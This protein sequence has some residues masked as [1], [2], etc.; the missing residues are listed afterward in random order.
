[1]FDVR[2]REYTCVDVMTVKDTIAPIFSRY[3]KDTLLTCKDTI[4]D[5][6]TVFAIDNCEG[7]VKVTFTETN[8]RGSD[9]NE[10]D[11][12]SYDI[13]RLYEA[14]DRCGNYTSMRQVLMIRDTTP[15]VITVA[16]NWRDTSLPKSLKGCLYAVPDYTEEVLMMVEDDCSEPTSIRV[17]QNPPAGTLIE[18]S[19]NVWIYVKDASGNMDSVAKYLRVQMRHEI[20][21]VTAPSRDTCVIQDQGLSL[22]SQNIRY[23]EGMVA[24]ERANGTIRMLPS[25]FCYDYYRG[26]VSPE[27]II[28]SDNPRTYASQFADVTS[29]YTSAFEAA[30]EL[31]CI[32]LYV[33]WYFR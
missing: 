31:T 11:Y 4:F 6:A 20:V 8:K 23:A 10:A 30:A 33:F 13:E 14:V 19:T 29:M 27:N 26:N 16:N 3:L 12:F 1:M 32:F 21:S 18:I 17:S 24:Y 28:Y 5:P 9:P 2:G 25:T 15:P 22:A 7:E